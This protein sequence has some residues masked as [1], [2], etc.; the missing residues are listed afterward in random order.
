M[1]V[2]ERH[3][4]A[5]TDAGDS[6]HAQREQ[7]LSVG[8]VAFARAL[9]VA[10]AVD[11]HDVAAAHVVVRVVRKEGVVGLDLAASIF[12]VDFVRAHLAVSP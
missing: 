8:V 10:E 11:G 7:T 1:A 9:R 12:V 6:P 5:G 4:T 3:E 2:A